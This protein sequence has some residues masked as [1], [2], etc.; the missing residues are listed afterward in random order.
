MRTETAWCRLWLLAVQ[1]GQDWAPRADEAS[2]RVS[3]ELEVLAD[4]SV[5]VEFASLHPQHG[6]GLR[7]GPAEPDGIELFVDYDAFR[8]GTRLVGRQLESTWARLWG[9]ANLR[10]AVDA[11]DSPSIVFA[12]F[13]V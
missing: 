4:S 3:L 6:L 13:V 11:G 1:H 12:V 8:A 9:L 2:V 7:V 10:G 5:A